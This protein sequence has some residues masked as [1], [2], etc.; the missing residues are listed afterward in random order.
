MGDDAKYRDPIHDEQLHMLETLLGRALETEEYEGFL[1]AGSRFVDR[2]GF[3]RIAD[4]KDVF[5][6]DTSA[7]RAALAASLC[8]IAQ[9]AG[10]YERYAREHR[11]T[12]I[13]PR[14]AFPL[15]PII[16]IETIVPR[17]F[18]ILGSASADAAAA[19]RTGHLPLRPKPDAA[20]LHETVHAHWCAYESWA[21]PEETAFALQI[22]PE[23]S[24]CRARAVI[25]SRDIADLAFVPYSF[26]PDDEGTRGLTFHGYFFEGRAQDHAQ[27]G[28]G[29][30]IAVFGAPPIESLERW[31]DG[32]WRT[33]RRL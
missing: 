18:R 33:V 25:L 17:V 22:K 21:S 20:V 28:F 16:G 23:W 9:D 2:F 5:R 30:Q 13:P 12:V 6:T 26:D 27:D 1:I 19:E 11:V 15:F 29:V 14:P 7:G 4:L 3:S 8:R 32:G 24:D 31:E 10:P